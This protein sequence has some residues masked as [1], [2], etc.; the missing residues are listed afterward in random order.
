MRPTPAGNTDAIPRSQ[1]ANSHWD[2]D[3]GAF[4]TARAIRLPLFFDR[5]AASPI[6]RLLRAARHASRL[7]MDRLAWLVGLALPALVL[8]DISGNLTVGRR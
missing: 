6:A 5:P 2:D 1:W 3:G 7:R 8:W 4:P